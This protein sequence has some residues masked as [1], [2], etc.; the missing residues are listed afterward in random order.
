MTRNKFATAGWLVA[1]GLAGVFLAGGFQGPADKFGMVDVNKAVSNSDLGKKN[2]ET[3]DTAVKARQGVIEF[4]R[5]QRVLTREQAT[6]IRDLSLKAAPTD[7]DKKDLQKI[8]N[9]V[10]ASA[11]NFDGLNQKTNLTDDDRKQLQE[12]HQSIDNTSSLV[13]EWSQS[14]GQELD[15]LQTQLIQDSIAKADAAIKDIG[16]K[17]GYSIVYSAPGATVYAANDITDAVTKALNAQK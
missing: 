3:L 10:I 9:D 6:K 16:K 14:F 12:Y 5:Q 4:M 8:Q 2:K 13:E 7:Q 11:K 1:A 17:E 15:A